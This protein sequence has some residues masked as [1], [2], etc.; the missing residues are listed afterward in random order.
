MCCGGAPSAGCMSPASRSRPLTNSCAASAGAHARR[1]NSGDVRR[2]GRRR[3]AGTEKRDEAVGAVEH[4]RD[5]SLTLEHGT[6]NVLLGPTL[7]GKTSLMRLMA[8]LDAPTSRPR[9]VRRQGCHRRAGA[10]AQRRHGLPA[11]H[12]LPRSDGLREHRLAAARRRRRA[13]KIDSEVRKR[14]RAAAARRPISTA[15]RSAFPA[16]SSSAPRSPARWSRTPASCCSTSRSPISTTSCARNCAP[17]C[18]ASSPNPARSSSMPRPSRRRRCCSAAIPRRCR[19][20][21]HAVR[22]DHR[23]LPQAARSRHRADLLRSAAQHHRAA[24]SAGRQFQ[25]DG[26]VGLPVPA[27]LAGIADGATRSA[28]ARTICPS[29]PPARSPSPLRGHGHGHR[30]HRLGKLRPRDFADARWVMLAHGVHD[31]E[32]D[33]E[34]EVFSIRATSWSSTA[35]AAPS[36]AAGWRLQETIWRGSS[37]TISATPTG[38]PERAPD[39][40]LKEVDHSFED[41]GAYALLGPSGCGKTTLLN[42]ISGLMQ[43]SAGPHP[44]QR[45]GRDRPATAGA[46]H[47]AGVPVPGDLR[48]HD[49]GR[50]LAFPLRNRGVPEPTRPRCARPSR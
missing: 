7:S 25:L 23:C 46:Q 19:G 16:A 42:I 38:P 15:R 2:P 36:R 37:S 29:T 33:A 12:Q 4:I 41:G 31:F 47:R 27:E 1:P 18:R 24:R 44:L 39:Y 10:A 14:G 11:V 9:L 45:Q 21:R 40:A 3:H 8:G 50:N 28:S 6:L 49:G 5:V 43:P 48:H 20:P 30:D 13:A 35:T 34:I 17:S 26:G 32:P 22:A